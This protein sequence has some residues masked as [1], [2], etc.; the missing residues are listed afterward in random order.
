MARPFF[1]L[2]IENVRTSRK[3]IESK[4][5]ENDREKE[6]HKKENKTTCNLFVEIRN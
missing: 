5:I 4:R 3:R 6:I 1:F 2:L